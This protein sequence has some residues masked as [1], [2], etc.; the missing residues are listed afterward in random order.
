MRARH[1]V[2]LVAVLMACFP[3]LEALPPKPLVAATNAYVL[4]SSANVQGQFG[5]YF[6]TR[7][8]LVNPNL[9]TMKIGVLAATP[10]GLLPTNPAFTLAPGQ[11]L[12][13][14]NFLDDAFQYTGGAALLFATNPDSLDPHAPF[15]LTAEVYVEGTSGRY[16]TPLQLL[17]EEDRVASSVDAGY[18]V[19]PGVVIDANN[20]ANVGCVNFYTSPA[21]I[22][23][24]LIGGATT[25]WS[26]TFSLQPYQWQQVSV[27]LSSAPSGSTVLFRS[28]GTPQNLWCYAVNV[29]NASND[30]TQIPA[31]YVIPSVL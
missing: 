15:L 20:R 4:A 11:V 13:L 6:K 12:V 17:G 29:N 16:S 1:H 19:S 14:T 25:L 7:V 21:T 28:S 31:I 3:H 10:S 18:S 9:S 27:S 23:A 22:T 24:S 8:V 30:G 26:N 5:A 2:A